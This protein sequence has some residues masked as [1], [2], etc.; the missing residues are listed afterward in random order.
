MTNQ[1]PKGNQEPS[2]QGEGGSAAPVP[3]TTAV[4]QH[5]RFR[6]QKHRALPGMLESSRD[7]RLAW[8]WLAGSRQAHILTFS[9]TFLVLG[10]HD[11]VEQRG[12]DLMWWAGRLLPLGCLCGC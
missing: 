10:T 7:Q 1:A 9:I 12:T 4:L 5:G 8:K 2:E 11:M 6:F 3:S